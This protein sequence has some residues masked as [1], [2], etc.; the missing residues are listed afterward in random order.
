M[1]FRTVTKLVLIFI[2]S[3]FLIGIS[4][5]AFVK[6]NQANERANSNLY[7]WVP[8][9][10]VGV[11]ESDNVEYFL[12]ELSHTTYASKLDTFLTTDFVNV[13]LTDLVGFASEDSHSLNNYMN[14]FVL[15]FHSNA[16]PMETVAYFRVGAEAKLYLQNFIKKKFG[17]DFTPKIET[18][19][20]SRIL[21][22]PLGC[23]L[24]MAVYSGKGV[25]AVSPQMKLIE[26]VIDARKDDTSLNDDAVFS[27][28]YQ[29]KSANFMSLYGRTPSVG[30]LSDELDCWSSYDVN[31]NREMFYLSGYTAMPDSDYVHVPDELARIKPMDEVGALVVVGQ[32]NVDACISSHIAAESPRMFDACVSSLSRDAAAIMVLDM[33]VCVD[34][35]AKFKNYLPTFISLFPWVFK[36]FI[37]S[38][39]L[40]V[41]EDTVYHLFTFTY[42]S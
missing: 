33:D 1:N 19:R 10:C 17:V 38:M 25:I 15:S 36:S 12:N 21:V 7:D 41:I 2:V 37:I 22:Y 42:K 30:S 29:K 31:F 6:L 13:V 32:K 24:Y 9:D 35:P 20:G 28:M 23:N 11:F 34:N 14:H 8:D 3:L 4:F 5:Y 40:T 16:D 18:Y 27:S 39:Q 26:R